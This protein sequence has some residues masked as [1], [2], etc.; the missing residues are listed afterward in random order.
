MLLYAHQIRVSF[1]NREIFSID[2]LSIYEG[3]KIGLIGMNGAGKSTLLKVLCGEAQ[4]DEGYVQR[5]SGCT[6]IPQ[7]GPAG[8]QAD[9]G[10]KSRL[11]VKNL[12]ESGKS[13]GEETRLKIAAALSSRAP[14][15]FADEPTTNLD[16][17]GISILKAALMAHSGALVLISHDRGL[18]DAVCTRII[19]LEDGKLQSY[20]G[21]YSDYL[22][23]KQRL[24]REHTAKYEKYTAEKSRLRRSAQEASRRAAAVKSTPSRMGNSEARLHKRASGKM[25]GKIESAANAISTRLDKLE[26]V[27][28]PRDVPDIRMAFEG[29][30]QPGSKYLAQAE[31][32]CLG[33]PGRPLLQSASLELPRGSKTALLGPNGS[34]KTTL[35]SWLKSTLPFAPS[36]RPAFFD[37]DYSM[38]RPGETMLE[39]ARRLT[40]RHDTAI[41]TVLACLLMKGDDVYKN[42]SVLSG[43]ELCKLCIACILLSGANLAVLDEP[44]NHLD[45]YS[46]EALAGVL[47]AWPGTLLFVSHDS[48]F[49]SLVADRFL[50]IDGG[51]LI[52][53]K[54]AEGDAL[55]GAASQ[56]EDDIRSRITLLEL[57]IAGLQASMKGADQQ[58]LS[59]LHARYLELCGQRDTLRARL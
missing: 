41:R 51:L 54:N 45:I 25:Q 58:S 16:V 34:G 27:D 6:V 22:R 26:K 1:A 23:K 21:N 46:I 36:A 19:E 5:Y 17:Q 35:L 13:G 47:A 31:N 50:K 8:T 20:A 4:P 3:E 32:I 52:P 2:E 9:E 38:L 53:C 7:L 14:L 55:G 28:R 56:R 39:N 44:T 48:A 49:S 59:G 11:G 37:Q 30:V 10:S 42:A 12:P 15:L 33:F 43:G 24:T 40:D 57:E 18:L 29:F